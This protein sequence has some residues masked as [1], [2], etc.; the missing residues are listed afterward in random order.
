[1]LAHDASWDFA[2]PLRDK[3]GYSNHDRFRGHIPVHC[4]SGLQP[5]CLRF[6]M[7]VAGHHARLGTRLLAKLCRGHSRRLGYMRFQGA[8][9]TDPYVHLYAYG[10]YLRCLTAKRWLG[11]G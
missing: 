1:M 3:V 8:T 10:S 6:A 7:A 2:F 11:Q 9:R 4:C 5:P